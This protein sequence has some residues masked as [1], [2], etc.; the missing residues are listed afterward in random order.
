MES[1]SD[2]H[3]RHWPGEGGNEVVG[4]EELALC[5]VVILLGAHEGRLKLENSAFLSLQKCVTCVKLTL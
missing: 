3:I 2:K 1:S 5:E 4:D